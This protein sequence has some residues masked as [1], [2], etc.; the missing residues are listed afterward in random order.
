[1]VMSPDGVLLIVGTLNQTNVH[2]YS[3]RDNDF[4]THII[5]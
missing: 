3:L 2:A 4:G 1:M 5:E